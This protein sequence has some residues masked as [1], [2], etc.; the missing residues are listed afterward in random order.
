MTAYW[1]LLLITAFLAYFIGSMK[2]M[3]IA[4]NFVFR[5]SLSRLGTGNVWL[6]NF[7][8]I[9][10]VRGFIKLA[11]V[12]IIKDLI[13]IL[14]GGLLL[15]IKNHAVAGRAFA[16]FC[17]VL[18]G[19]YPVFY[20]FKGGHAAI[21]MVISAISVDTS[22]GIATAAFVAGATWFTKYESLGAVAG[23]LVLIAASV[24][25]V[26]DRAAMLLCVLTGSLVIFKHI[27]AMLRLSRGRE[28]KFSLEEDISYKFDEKF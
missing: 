13:P 7:R 19:L 16:G 22:V 5:R 12:E 1:I 2:S 9:Y 3:V 14:I 23:A 24:L 11:L 26:D 10:G 15:G 28:Q 4:S 18:A 20:D 17:M 6:S 8:R 21:Y 25:V 27:P